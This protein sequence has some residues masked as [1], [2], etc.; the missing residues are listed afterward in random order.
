MPAD[1]ERLQMTLDALH[2]QLAE[3]GPLDVDSRNRLIAALHEIQTALRTQ[4]PPAESLLP[5]LRDAATSFEEKHPAISTT[6]ANL[7]DILARMGI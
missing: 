5:R 3:I 7:I 6:V 1:P 4:S 2:R